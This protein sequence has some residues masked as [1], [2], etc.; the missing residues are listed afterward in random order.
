MRTG[1]SYSVSC[2][3][4]WAFQN[5]MSRAFCLR[6]ALNCG[7]AKDS[8]GVAMNDFVASR[9]AFSMS[10]TTLGTWGPA[11][12]NG[13][14]RLCGRRAAQDPRTTQSLLAT[15]MDG[16]CDWNRYKNLWIAVDRGHSGK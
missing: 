8:G 12:C 15:T 16:V 11:V 3:R 2:S 9:F 1:Y 14:N 4:E 13:V 6:V 5:G 10:A 7:S